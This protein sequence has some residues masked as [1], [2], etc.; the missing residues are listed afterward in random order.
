MD[1]SEN[2]S[3]CDADF[4]GGI[5]EM[6]ARFSSVI[7]DIKIVH[8]EREKTVSDMK[9]KSEVAQHKARL[10]EALRLLNAE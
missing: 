10:E 8:K 4:F 1:L 3:E 2:I 9:E 6:F 7:E 5:A